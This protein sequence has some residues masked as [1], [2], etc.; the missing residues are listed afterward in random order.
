MLLQS[1]KNLPDIVY[2]HFSFLNT[3]DKVLM[4][5]GPGLAEKNLIGRR[6]TS[7]RFELVECHSLSKMDMCVDFLMI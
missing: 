5:I 1:L 6:N 2:I 3:S 7:T 4:L